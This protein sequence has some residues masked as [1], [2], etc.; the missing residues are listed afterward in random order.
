MTE[1]DRCARC[2]RPRASVLN[3]PLELCRGGEGQPC[4][5]Q[6]LQRSPGPPVVTI[7]SDLG[8]Q[9][10]AMRQQLDSAQTETAQLKQQMGSVTAELESAREQVTRHQAAAEQAH[11]AHASAQALAEGL[12][13]ELAKLMSKPALPD[14][15]PGPTGPTPNLI[16]RVVSWLAASRMVLASIA[17]VLG[18][19][20][21]AGGVAGWHYTSP[22]PAPTPATVSASTLTNRIQDALPQDLR[23]MLLR[24]DDATKRVLVDKALLPADKERATLTINSVYSG[25]GLQ[26]PAIDFPP[27][28]V[29]PDPP[30][31]TVTL[32]ARDLQARIDDALRAQGLGKLKARVEE[33]TGSGNVKVVSVDVEANA[34]A[35][36][37]RADLIIRSVFKGAGLPEPVLQHPVTARHAE[38]P[39]RSASSTPASAAQT[40]ASAPQGADGRGPLETECYRGQNPLQQLLNWKPYWCMRKKC[41]GQP[42]AQ[43]QEC[44]EFRAKPNNCP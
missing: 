5:R 3:D 26:R 17:S 9:L 21:G 22:T 40:V 39:I 36:A 28:P 7:P 31:V 2:N 4:L 44:I 32:S 25:A 23:G 19:A 30:P 38:P 12:K 37:A 13:A 15:S 24:V 10:E 41:C 6:E 14:T 18:I 16:R 42:M 20:L 34:S 35:Q 8:R 1:Q 29:P 11:G 43:N 33:S 27:D